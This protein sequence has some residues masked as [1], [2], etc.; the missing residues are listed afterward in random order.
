MRGIVARGGDLM[1]QGSTWGEDMILTST[2]LR[3][4]RFA[5]ALT[6]VEI[7]PRSRHDLAMTSSRPHSDPDTMLATTR[8]DLP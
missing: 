5:T 1:Y 8:H 7:S 4:T 3:D 2:V 6:Y